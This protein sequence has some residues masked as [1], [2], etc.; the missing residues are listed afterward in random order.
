VTI[1]AN[2]CVLCAASTRWSLAALLAEYGLRGSS[3]LSSVLFIPGASGPYTSSVETWRKRATPRSRATSSSTWVPSTL[4]RRNG[5]PAWIERSTCVSAAKWTTQ[6]SPSQ[7]SNARR[8]SSTS[9][10][11]PLTK[12]WSRPATFSRLPA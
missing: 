5:R 10:T 3:R 7:W 9:A 2:P 4:V 6:V 12:V 1:A 11:S 8:T